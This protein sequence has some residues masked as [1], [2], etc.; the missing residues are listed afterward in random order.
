MAVF[1]MFR[2]CSILFCKSVRSFMHI[3]TGYRGPP[4]PPAC[5][6]AT[7]KCVETVVHGERSQDDVAEAASPAEEVLPVSTEDRAKHYFLHTRTRLR[8]RYELELTQD[9]WDGWCRLI[10]T[11]SPAVV[12]VEAREQVT[13][14]RVWF[15]HRVVYT[16]F[17]D[18]AIVTVLP[19]K[20]RFSSLVNRALR[21]REI[22]LRARKAEVVLRALEVERALEADAALLAHEE[23]VEAL[24]ETT[25]SE[26]VSS[27][28]VVKAV[29]KEVAPRL[30]SKPAIQ[31]PAQKLTKRE[32][33]DRAVFLSAMS[34]PVMSIKKKDGRPIRDDEALTALRAKAT[35][36]SARASTV[37]VAVPKPA[38]QSQ[39]KV[40][41]QAKV[42]RVPPR[43]GK[44]A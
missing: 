9:I 10:R 1:F 26:P 25:A 27:D 20:D 24:P 15:G 2:L 22:A 40:S 44:G 5:T 42:V 37:A 35:T 34:N 6:L 17:K 13:L 30:V 21:A 3:F 12:F 41:T 38:D 19:P 7:G 18:D 29:I 8:E 31:P 4:D 43:M 16:V 14:W 39:V 32:E 28:A 23:Q 33:E 11:D 36:K